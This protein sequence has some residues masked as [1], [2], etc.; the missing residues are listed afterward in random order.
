MPFL[1]TGVCLLGA[2]WIAWL[3]TPFCRRFAERHGFVDDPGGRK[4]H[5]GGRSLLG[6]AAVFL[7]LW[8]IVAAGLLGAGLLRSL[9]VL[10][11]WLG[12]F[13]SDVV[14]LA[15]V[16]LP[17]AGLF[18][19]SLIVGVLGARDDRSPLGAGA[20]LLG[21]VVAA[22]VTVAAGAQCQFLPGGQLVNAIASVLWIVTITNAFNFIDNMDGLCAGVGAISGAILLAVALTQRQYFMAM[23]LASHTG[24][25]LGFLRFNFP[26]ASIFLGDL[27]S[28]VI[29]HFLGSVTLLLSYVAG[30]GEATLA[31]LLPPIA[32]GLPLLDLIRVSVLRLRQ[33][34]PVWVGDNQHLSHRLRHDETTDRAVLARLYLLALCLG[35]NALLL[36]GA[37]PWQGAVIGLLTVCLGALVWMLLG[38]DDRAHS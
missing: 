20:K 19:G 4:R 10:E 27:G 34:R 6:G 16:G 30:A 1:V 32:L 18:G 35:G 5:A 26:P 25:C 37:S 36:I 28:H 33:G 21:Q 38:P 24:A 7:G 11:P 14:E 22:S 8:S 2:G 29:G 13:G 9:G 17:L 3:G 31:V 23:I 15:R 12:P